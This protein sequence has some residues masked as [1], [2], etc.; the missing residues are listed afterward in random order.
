[1]ADYIELNGIRTW[2]DEQGAGEPLVLLHPGGIGVDSRAF[3]PNLAALTSRFRVFL[4]ERRGHGHTPDAEGSY[5]YE[6]MA[7]DTIRFL[8]LI[9]GSS[10]RLLGMSDGAI[11]ALMVTLKRPDLVE[12]L[13]CA[14]GVFNNNGWAEGVIEPID[15][16]P[17][18]LITSYKKFSPDGIEHLPVVLKKLNEMHTNGPKLTPKN[19]QKISCRTLVMIG[20]DDEVILEHAIDFYRNLPKGELA[21]IPGTSHGL[22]VEKPELCNKIMV[23]FLTL[24]PITTLAPIRRE[25]KRKG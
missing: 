6:L 23:D 15:E 10:T 21:V 12:R 14:A 16:P 8:E 1:M 9:V 5:S 17:E 13:I 11:V 18:F 25:A 22:L 2:Y 20:D 4:P 7:D 3:G 24:D 19:L